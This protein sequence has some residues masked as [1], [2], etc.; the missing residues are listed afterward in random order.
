[1]DF[2]VQKKYREVLIT[3]AQQFAQGFPKIVRSLRLEYKYQLIDD[4]G[5]VYGRCL[6]AGKLKTKAC[7]H[8]FGNISSALLTDSIQSRNDL[9][10]KLRKRHCLPKISDDSK[11]SHY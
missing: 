10:N 5:R 8:V 6:S 2:K 7:F 11:Q 1:M 3:M 4:K 9:E